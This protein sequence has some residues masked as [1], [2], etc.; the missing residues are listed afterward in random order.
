M[1]P[2]NGWDLTWK[3]FHMDS[4]EW[5]V[6]SMDSIWINLGSVKTSSQ[7]CMAVSIDIR[8]ALGPLRGCLVSFGAIPTCA[9][10]CA[11]GF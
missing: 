10:L 11:P 2:A 8:T 6:D 4:M 9:G 5:G 7:G 3:S 1:E